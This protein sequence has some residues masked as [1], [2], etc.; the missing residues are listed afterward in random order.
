MDLAGARL[1][2]TYNMATFA[3][4]YLH[5]ATLSM[6]T[7]ATASFAGANLAGATLRDVVLQDAD[8]SGADLTGAVLQNVV[9]GGESWT[10]ATCPDGLTS[11]LRGGTCIGDPAITVID[12]TSATRPP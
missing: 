4:A 7:V 3:G 12:P 11:D 10:R 2:G 5:G 9:V 8:F 1:E 6:A